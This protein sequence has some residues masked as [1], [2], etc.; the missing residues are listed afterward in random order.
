LIALVPSLAAVALLVP[1]AASA[2]WSV[3]ETPAF[4]KI[5]TEAVLLG[6]SC[7]SAESCTA[8]GYYQHTPSIRLPLAEYWNGKEWSAQE[9][10]N[11]PN[12]AYT[13]TSELK[14]VSCQSSASCT[15]V[16]SYTPGKAVKGSLVEHTLAERWNGTEWTIQTTPN[17]TEAKDSYLAGVSCTSAEACTAVGRYISSAGKTLALAERWNG[18]EWSIQETKI[19]TGSESSSLS[20]VSCTTSEACSAVGHYVNSSGVEVPLAER[21]NGK[22]WSIQETKIPTGA[23]SSSLSSVSCTT[24]EACSAVGHYVNSSSVEVPLAEG[25]NGK[26]WSIQET[27]IP[28]EA[29]SSS[30]AGLWCTSSKA[31]TAVGKYTNSAGTVVTLAES[32]NG[33]LWSIQTT[34]NPSGA[35][36]S[37]L[38][39]VSCTSAEA[40]T[41]AGNYTN[42]ASKQITLAER[43]NGKAWAIQTS[44]PKIEAEGQ[45]AGD[46]TGVSCTSTEACTAVGWYQNNSGKNQTLAERWN[47]KEWSIQL[48][49]NPS[50]AIESHLF[51][52]SCSSAE[53]CI[54][55]GYYSSSENPL[56]PFA[57]RWNG[58]EW[59]LQEVK[60]PA[61]SK[62]TVLYDVS[63]SSSE[64]CS[65]TGAYTNSA[66]TAVSL[67]ER[68]N[69][70]EWSIQETPNPAESTSTNLHGVSCV[71]AEACTAVGDYSTKSSGSHDLSFAERWNGKTWSL[72][73]T[74][75]PTGAI[76]TYLVGVSC[77]SSEACT[78]A[79]DYIN[80]VETQLTLAERWNGKEWSIQETKTPPGATS[81]S[82][83]GVSC[84]TS[85]ACTAVGDY[86][87]AAEMQVSLAERWNG[88]E[89]SIEET[90][91]P[92]GAQSSSMGSISCTS[93]SSCVAVGTYRNR[94]GLNA[95][96]VEE[97]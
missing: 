54:A 63:C 66:G 84:A 2:A 46:S 53:A 36:S 80:S 10:P 3:R 70:K 87:N 7:T 89:W 26:E 58:K 18:K 24:S 57:A 88:K 67:V 59:S 96:L 27:K 21:W 6:V 61:E 16:G 52:V 39:G 31:C 28:T 73:E 33:L 90:P 76:G 43:W 93:A 30:L 71:S 32:W 8:A 23:K 20:S 4:P 83:I 17:P 92:K 12:G 29:K 11:S 13:T 65:A 42:S 81:S 9:V 14:G 38:S 56:R 19:P 78:A 5:E 50:E 74:K 82:I 77:T 40:C 75:T 86:T 37:I 55:V 34:E 94:A 35:K 48:T 47:G 15:A 64:A 49:P 45:L 68:W 69:G 60:A 72:E 95:P 41:A 97:V 85:E 22:E 62:G 51:G 44:N 79:G 1:A 25:W 91:N